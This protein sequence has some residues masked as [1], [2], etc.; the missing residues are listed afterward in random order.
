MLALG[1][2]NATNLTMLYLENQDLKGLTPAQLVEKYIQI[3]KE[4]TDAI[5]LLGSY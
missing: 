1:D 3:K 2:I 4:I 5:N